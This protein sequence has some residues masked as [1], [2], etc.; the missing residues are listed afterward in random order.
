M[1]IAIDMDNTIIDELGSTLRPGILDFLEEISI[2]HELIL[3][4]NAK[5]IRTMEI[6]DYFNLRKY[7]VKILS[8]E[9]YDPEEK[10]LPK[11]LTR[12]GYDA[13]IDD[14]ITEIEYNKNK[15]KIGILVESYRKHNTSNEK[16]FKQLMRFFQNI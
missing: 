15:G 1:K 13:I 6:L 12:Y 3:W 5:R 14:D 9:N 2:K 16:E 11:D 8:R 4:T 10:G 7:F